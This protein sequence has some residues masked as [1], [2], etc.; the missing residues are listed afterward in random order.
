MC[1][2]EKWKEQ[3]VSNMARVLLREMSIRSGV[4]CCF[5]VTMGP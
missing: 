1:F 2:M 5:Y 4:G 3:M